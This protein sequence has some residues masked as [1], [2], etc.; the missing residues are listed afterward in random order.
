MLTG[1]LELLHAV[2]L[3]SSNM[4]RI[5]SRARRRSILRIIV[6][7]VHEL[8]ARTLRVEVIQKVNPTG[9]I[10]LGASFREVGLGTLISSAGD[11]TRGRRTSLRLGS[12]GEALV[13]RGRIA[14]G[15][16]NRSSSSGGSGIGLGQLGRRRVAE[17]QT[18]QLVDVEAQ[19]LTYVIADR[20]QT[21]DDL[22]AQLDLDLVL[23]PAEGLVEDQLP[24]LVVAEVLDRRVRFVLGALEDQRGGSD[25]GRLGHALATDS[26]RRWDAA[27][28]I[29]LVDGGHVDFAGLLHGLGHGLIETSEAARV[30][31]QWDG[32]DGARGADWSRARRSVLLAVLLLED[33]DLRLRGLPELLGFLLRSAD[34][35]PLGAF[36]VDGGSEL[37]E[38]AA[39]VV[40][41][42]EVVLRARDDVPELS[43]VDW[44][45]A[46]VPF[47]VDLL[48]VVEHLHLDLIC[49]GNFG[50]LVEALH[51]EALCLRHSLVELETTLLVFWALVR[52]VEP[53]EQRRQLRGKSPISDVFLRSFLA[54][55]GDRR[56]WDRCS[57]AIVQLNG[58]AVLSNGRTV[59]GDVVLR[60]HLALRL[61]VD[62][63]EAGRRRR[64][65]HFSSFSRCFEQCRLVGEVEGGQG[66]E[67]VDPQCRGVFI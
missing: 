47:L 5:G 59:V 19:L 67:S 29:L 64:I 23:E 46:L 31:L 25:W 13:E 48:A 44:G 57:S 28:S 61:S 42:E 60:I 9:D 36:V 24:G 62:R 8:F 3:V 43:R 22:L 40:H 26:E 52:L 30:E 66:V 53:V 37:D 63:S 38:L 45:E 21:L 56:R 55:L 34:L 16:G 39:L 41:S 58:S 65:G 20:L 27:S 18:A 7:N 33:V 35:Q 17:D 11:L 54:G 14:G 15:G 6:I 10:G 12:D 50:V 32:E 51:A 1:S 49:S 4:T 2:A